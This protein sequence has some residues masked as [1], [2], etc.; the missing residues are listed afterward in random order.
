MNRRFV[1]MSAMTAKT[2][3]DIHTH[4]EAFDGTWTCLAESG[5]YVCKAKADANACNFQFRAEE[6]TRIGN[7]EIT[8]ENERRAL[9][10]G[11]FGRALSLHACGFAASAP[12]AMPRRK[13]VTQPPRPRREW[14]FASLAWR[15]PLRR[16][17]CSI[18]IGSFLCGRWRP[19]HQIGKLIMATVSFFTSRA[20]AARSPPAFQQFCSPS[21][22]DGR[23][24]CWARLWSSTGVAR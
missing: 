8:Q 14:H 16:H 24:P 12:R 21:S 19:T 18:N 10:E 17:S 5:A 23:A 3:S 6:E 7:S 1:N 4:N 2:L 22:E 13:N 15:A 9:S 11:L 20:I